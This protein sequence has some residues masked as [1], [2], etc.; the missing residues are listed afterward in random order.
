MANRDNPHGLIPVGRTLSGGE[1]R[2]KQFSKDSSGGNIFIHDV[3]NREADGN[4][5]AGGTPGTTTYTGVSLNYSATGAAGTH[6]V[7]VSPDAM[8]VAQDNADTDGIAAADLGLNCNF[9]FNAGSADSKISGHEL[10][11]SSADTTNTL[12][13]KLHELW[14][15]PNNEHSAN[16][17]IV[18]TINKHRLAQ[19]TGIAGV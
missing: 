12:D 19:G 9:E 1:P 5:T 11:E 13:A 8:F 16:A 2:V 7:V 15:S 4:I 17:D 3:V 18:I 10:D 14:N 6:L